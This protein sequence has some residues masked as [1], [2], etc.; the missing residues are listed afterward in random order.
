M[1][2][3]RGVAET[4]VVLLRQGTEICKREQDS[5]AHL[6]LGRSGTAFLWSRAG[7][8]EGQRTDKRADVMLSMQ[9]WGMVH[10][11]IVDCGINAR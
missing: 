10:W 4:Q 2:K 5:W 1:T 7:R 11:F 3:S 9:N 8:R 6:A